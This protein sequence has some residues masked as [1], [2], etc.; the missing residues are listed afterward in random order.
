MFRILGIFVMAGA[1]L[2][3]A[4]GAAASLGTSGGAAQQGSQSAS[5][6]PSSDGVTIT[7]VLDNQNKVDKVEIGDI[8]TPAC[9]GA[10]VIVTTK[11]TNNSTIGALSGT[12]A[13]HSGS[14]ATI[15]SEDANVSIGN[16]GSV[17]VIIVHSTIISSSNNCS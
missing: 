7:Y 9:D 17:E 6:D 13:D 15:G 5:C 11:D 4:Y 14:T 2:A 12:C 1:L 10:D 3:A 8:A 16:I